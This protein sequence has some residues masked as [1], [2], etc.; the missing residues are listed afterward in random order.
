MPAKNAGTSITGTCMPG[1]S[2]SEPAFRMTRIRGAGA[3]ASILA[4]GRENASTA[5]QQPST[6]PAPISR[7]RGEC[8]C[9]TAPRPIFRH[10]AIRRLGRLRSIAALI[11]MSACRRIGSRHG[12]PVADRGWK[13]P[14][15]DPIPLPR[16]RQL[17][18][19]E[20]AGN[21]ITKL[22]RAAHEAKEWQAAMEA[23]ILG[24]DIG[25]TD[26][27]CADWRHEG[28]RPPR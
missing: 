12:P 7:P 9:R 20:D 5:R 19:L 2:Q 23:L 25:R 14:F 15:D 26:D 21:Y 24:R 22:P 10:G 16:S 18:T 4:V 13:R 28:I 11:G 17:V 27:V 3:A 8:F 6:R 1:R